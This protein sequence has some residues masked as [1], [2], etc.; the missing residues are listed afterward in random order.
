MFGKL[1][2]PDNIEAILWDMDGVLIDSLG[3][4]MDVC[5]SLVKEYFGENVF[6][7]KDYIQSIFAYHVPEFIRLI[8]EK[9]KKDYSIVDSQKYYDVILRRYNGERQNFPFQINPGILDIL[10]NIKDSNL[11]QAVV[12][13]NPTK[14]I[15]EILRNCNLLEY[16]DCIIGNDLVVN[17]VKLRKKPFPD[18]YFFSS[19]KLDVNIK[20]CMV[21]EDSILGIQ[22]GVASGSYTIGVG[23]GSADVKELLEVDGVMKVYNSF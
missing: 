5:N 13:N 23:T 11:K 21:V 22:A 1:E 4:D 10:K 19:K 6:L 15:E 3:L 12:S 14:D 7:S 2:V 20:N 8:L 17:G 16:F 9:I 18:T